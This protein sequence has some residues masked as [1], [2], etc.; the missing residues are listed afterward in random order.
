MSLFKGTV[1]VDNE[2]DVDLKK[3]N[4][5]RYD[6]VLKFGDHVRI[7]LSKKQ[8]LALKNSIDDLLER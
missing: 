2:D 3:H 8:I 7:F 4:G 5:L 1:H 6:F